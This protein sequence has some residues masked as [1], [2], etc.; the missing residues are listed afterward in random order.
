MT[1]PL[2]KPPRVH[3]GRV[4][5]VSEPDGIVFLAGR[6]GSLDDSWPLA[7]LVD[8]LDQRG[9]RCQI[10]CISRGRW[11]EGDPRVLEFPALGNR[12][13]W[14]LAIRRLRLERQLE[15]V[16]LLHIMRD[17]LAAAGLALAE[18]IAIPY[19]LTVD[20]FATLDHGLK[21]SHRYF[22]GLVATTAELAA[23]FID[24]LDFPAEAI[25]LIAP[26]IGDPL[27]SDRTTRGNIP[28]VGTAGVPRTGSDFSCFLEAA[29][30]IIS[31]GRDTE[32]LIASQGKGLYELRRQAQSLRIADR[33][34]V[35][36]F[37]TLSERFYGALDVYCQ[38]SLVPS[39][40]RTLT[41][42]LAEAVPSVASRVR[43]LESLIDHGRSG[44]LVP[45]GDSHALAASLIELLDDRDQATSLGLFAQEAILD[46]FNLDRQ[47]DLLVDLYRDC[48]G[49]A[50]PS[51]GLPG[52]L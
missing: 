41:L 28:V 52:P 12:W 46:R 51:V 37:T 18:A 47:A 11:P 43:G 4:V 36:D 33:V 49:A 8:R 32:F 50:S 39:T 6:L 40:G 20:D 14:P 15:D 24:V 16:C 27:G 9:V 42:A 13:L 2:A 21:L 22:R 5:I 17:E 45:P 26:G 29:G 23:D 48:L 38:P 3:P 25:S 19:L 31:S 7:T 30:K 44:L 1:V 10:V 35:A 34:T